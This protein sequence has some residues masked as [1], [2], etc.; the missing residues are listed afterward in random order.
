MGNSLDRMVMKAS[1]RQWHLS[2]NLEEGMPGHA[3]EGKLQ[4]EEQQLQSLRSSACLK[5]RERKKVGCWSAVKGWGDWHET[6]S[7][8]KRAELLKGTRRNMNAIP[9]ECIK[10]R[11]INWLICFGAPWLVCE[12][13]T[14]SGARAKAQ[15]PGDHAVSQKC[16]GWLAQGG[17]SGDPY[18]T[19]DRLWV[20]W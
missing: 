12:K 20:K 11:T 4:A 15:R 17:S 18:C 5:E 16:D 10:R 2:R 9:L 8:T 14:T 19:E 13:W 1:W 6:R 3:G 7:H